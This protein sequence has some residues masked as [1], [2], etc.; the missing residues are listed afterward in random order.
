MIERRQPPLLRGDA[1]LAEVK[2]R[3]SHHKRPKAQERK[4]ATA[5]GG[6]RVAGSG[7][8]IE[9]GDVARVVQSFPIRVECKRSMGKASIPF[10][11]AHLVKISSE[12][13]AVGAFPALALQFDK[14]VMA[15]IAR[16]RGCMPASEDWIAVP[17]HVFQA[18]LEALGEEGILGE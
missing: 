8:G 5:I 7:S 14:D 16:E 18:M 9:K 3:Q 10:K 1:G 4:V 13:M 6:R 15:R 11:A 2:H 12:A 17:L